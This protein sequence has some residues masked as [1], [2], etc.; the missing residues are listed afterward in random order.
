[1]DL[2]GVVGAQPGAV[3]DLSICEPGAPLSGIA[4]YWPRARRLSVNVGPV[5]LVDYVAEGG[6]LVRSIFDLPG[7]AMLVVSSGTVE[8]LEVNFGSPTL[9]KSAKGKALELVAGDRRF[10][11]LAFPCCEKDC[12]GKD[13]CTDEDAMLATLRND[14]GLLNPIE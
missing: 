9:R 2:A 5:E 11:G 4:T 3:A 8:E 14:P 7:K 1:M 10:T 12:E 6:A 13:A